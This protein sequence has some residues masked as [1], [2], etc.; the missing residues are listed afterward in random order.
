MMVILNINYDKNFI[1]KNFVWMHLIK[2]IEGGFASM[3][4]IINFITRN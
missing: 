4:N 3:K 2:D 1:S